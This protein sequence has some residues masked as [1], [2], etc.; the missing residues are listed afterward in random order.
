MMSPHGTYPLT[1]NFSINLQP[2]A[3]PEQVDFCWEQLQRE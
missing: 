1:A 3:S 2:G